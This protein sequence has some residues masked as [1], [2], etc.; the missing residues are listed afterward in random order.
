VSKD[1]LIGVSKDILIEML[2]KTGVIS[3]KIGK[4]GSA[5]ASNDKSCCEASN[6]EESLS[7]SG[8]SSYFSSPIERDG[9]LNSVVSIG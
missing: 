3:E 2:I 1:K 5:P 8:D 9:F 7:N 4:Q 6:N